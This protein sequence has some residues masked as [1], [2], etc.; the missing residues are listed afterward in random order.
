MDGVYLEMKEWRKERR[1]SGFSEDGKEQWGNKRV[2]DRA[3][4]MGTETEGRSH[5]QRGE[6]TC[7]RTDRE[8]DVWVVCYVPNSCLRG[9]WVGRRLASKYPLVSPRLLIDRSAG[10]SSS[11]GSSSSAGPSS[12]ACFRNSSG[13]VQTTGKTPFPFRLSCVIG[14]ESSSWFAVAS[15]CLFT[16]AET[17]R[18]ERTN[19]RVHEWMSQ[20][21]NQSFHPSINQCVNQSIC[22]SLIENWC[23]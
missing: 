8:E 11:A 2:T 10:P 13:F 22:Q 7:R 6:R 18:F 23:I 12:S 21:I 1:N 9:T 4:K 16:R 19:Q 3:S 15:V 14:Y 17:A 20:L 5:K